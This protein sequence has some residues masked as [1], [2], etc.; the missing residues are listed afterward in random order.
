MI[1]ASVLIALISALG[2]IALWHLTR[3]E[4]PTLTSLRVL[5]QPRVIADFA[6]VDEDGERFTLERLRDTW[7]L[8]FFGFT[9]CPDVCPSTLYDLQQVHERI[10]GSKA[11]G[12]DRHQVLFVSVDPERDDPQRLKRYTDFFHEDFIGLT[13][14]HRQ[15]EP[16]SMQLGIAYRIEEH[17]AGSQTYAVDHSASVLL[18]EPSGRLYGVFPAPHDP[19]AMSA[20]LAAI[21]DRG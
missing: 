10:S 14:E 6:L 8:V 19:E 17:E 15:L 2:G 12:Q 9:H 16:L 1:V 18:L 7:S 3:P 11:E 5:P 4:P 13:G 20:D 21:L